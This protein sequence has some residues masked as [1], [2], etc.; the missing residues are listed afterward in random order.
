MSKDKYGSTTGFLDLIFNT[1]LAFVLLFLLMFIMI[2]TEETK[3]KVDD[4]NEIVIT[5]TWDDQLADDVDLWLKDPHGRLVG[6]TNKE[7]EGIALE[8]DDMGSITD[9]VIDSKGNVI[10]IKLN[11][12]IMNIRHLNAGIYTIN[13][14]MFSKRSEG[15]VDV[16]VKII[17]INPFKEFPEVKK[18]L[19]ERG[20][21][22][23][24]VTF[25]IDGE[26]KIVNINT[27]IEDLFVLNR[28]IGHNLR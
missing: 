10:I 26:G 4:K 13:A 27:K 15:P 12:E 5:L 17:K 3:T 11:Q 14:H 7:I 19:P 18:V 16:K 8:R 23:T 25:E 1:L 6:F 9:R 24:M 28:V 2:K 20:S 22:V 21:E